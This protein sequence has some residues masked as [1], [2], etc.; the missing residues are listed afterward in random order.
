[1][2]AVGCGVHA[3][4]LACFRSASSFSSASPAS[5]SHAA[6][7]RLCLFDIN[8]CALGSCGIPFRPS[9]MCVSRDAEYV[10]VVGEERLMVLRLHDLRVRSCPYQASC[11]LSLLQDCLNSI[12]FRTPLDCSCFDDLLNAD[13][14]AGD[15]YARLLLLRLQRTAPLCMRGE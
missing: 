6:P 7:A 3:V 13:A 8:L 11:S 1:M 15:M 2:V 14:F 12:F 9:D 10:C 4:V 5:S